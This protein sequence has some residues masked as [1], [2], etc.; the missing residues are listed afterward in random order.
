MARYMLP[1][2]LAMICVRSINKRV[3]LRV[4]KVAIATTFIAHGY[5]AIMLNPKFIDFIIRIS[6]VYSGVAISEATASSM[7]YV[8]GVVDIFV[9]I[10]LLTFMNRFSIA[11]MAFW[12]GLTALA[13]VFFDPTNGPTDMII[14]SAHFAVPFFLYLSY[15]G[16]KMPRRIKIIL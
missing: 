8:I 6:R 13:R 3:I 14:R 10:S 16:F 9:A 5:E 2:A 4:L 15:Y 12:G 7:L 11:Y 1:F